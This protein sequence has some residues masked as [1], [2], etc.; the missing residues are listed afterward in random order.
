MVNPSIVLLHFV[1]SILDR[2]LLPCISHELEIL[3]ICFIVHLVVNF[4]CLRH[5]SAPKS[6]CPKLLSRL[7]ILTIG[8]GIVRIRVHLVG[9]VFVHVFG[10]CL[11]LHTFLRDFGVPFFRVFMH[12][13]DLTSLFFHLLLA[14]KAT[15]NH[16]ELVVLLCSAPLTAQLNGE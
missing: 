14:R 4:L 6:V 16:V 7:F 10:G 11:L 15:L 5:T 3:K 8:H 2:F 9:L 13:F 12:G 1:Q